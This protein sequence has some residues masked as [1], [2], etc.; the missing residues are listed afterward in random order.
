MSDQVAVGVENGSLFKGVD[1]SVEMYYKYMQNLVE[2]KN[3]AR[4]I[5]NQHIETALIP[6]RGFSAGIELSAVKNSGRL[7]GMFRYVFSRTF[8]KTV[9]PY[10][11]ENFM[12]GSYYPSMYDKPHDIIH[13]L[14]LPVSI[15]FQDKNRI[16]KMNNR[17]RYRNQHDKA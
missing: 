5:M 7:K 15:N 17:F 2:Y 13:T 4:L 14:D 1:L 11:E 16:F 8:Q 12:K 10:G 6:A 3:G 9:S